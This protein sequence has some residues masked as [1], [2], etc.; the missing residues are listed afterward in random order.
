M[1][2]YDQ[3]DQIDGDSMSDYYQDIRDKAIAAGAS[4]LV[5]RFGTENTSHS[6]CLDYL[7]HI[8]NINP[9]LAELCA[10]EFL[11]RE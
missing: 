3:Y 2:D 7:I 4:I 5:E 6:A 9:E 1:T 11:N 10:S 8:E